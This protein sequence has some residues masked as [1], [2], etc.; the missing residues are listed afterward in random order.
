[1]KTHDK[2]YLGG[3]WVVPSGR[4]SFEVTD[5]STEEVIGRVP[6]G[7]VEDVS[8]AARGARAAFD[9]WSRTSPAERA[10]YLEKIQ[11]GLVART[12]EIAEIVA[13]EVGMP[14]ALSTMIQAGL[15]T[16]SFAAAAQMA[17]SYEFESGVG[18]S[19]IVKEPVGVVGAITPWNY[20]LHQVA[21]KVAP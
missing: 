19:V 16:L 18:T 8:R 21:A 1:M 7:D 11:A 5:A 10:S 2:I 6:A 20:P 3:E 12:P 15:P 9:R 4:G 17:K 14:L 13:R